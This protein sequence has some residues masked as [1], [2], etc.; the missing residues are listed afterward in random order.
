[1]SDQ[2]PYEDTARKA[3]S[4]LEAKIR[5]AL[6]TGDVRW[7]RLFFNA[8]KLPWWIRWR[9]SVRRWLR[10]MEKDV[11]DYIQRNKP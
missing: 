5:D 7:F 3:I 6:I 10:Q 2:R 9:P 8:K 4:E 1:M 11:H